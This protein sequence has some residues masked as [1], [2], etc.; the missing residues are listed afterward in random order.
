MTYSPTAV[1]RHAYPEAMRQLR[2]EH[3]FTVACSAAYIGKLL[4][5]APQHRRQTLRFLLAWLAGWSLG[6]W[7]VSAPPARRFAP[8]WL[9]GAA[10]IRGGLRYAAYHLTGQ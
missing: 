5:E 2:A 8:A 7:N 10:L 1:V 4:V 6:G 3:L 9:T